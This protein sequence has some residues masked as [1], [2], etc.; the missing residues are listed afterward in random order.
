VRTADDTQMLEIA[1][2]ENLQREDLNPIEVG[3]GYAAYI[4]RLGLTQQETADRLGKSR[5]AVANT[6]RLLE[7]PRDLQDLVSR[8][9]ISAGHARALLSL[10]DAEGQ[11]RMAQRVVDDGLS[12]RDVERTVR[13]KRAETAQAEPETPAYLGTLEDRL[14]LALGTRVRIRTGRG[15]RGSIVIDYFSSDEL[16]RLIDCLLPEG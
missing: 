1:L 12:V 13:P 16:S 14:K 3:R 2:V 8:G 6:L 4:E 9:T 15:E 10:P 5:S 11:R 7:L